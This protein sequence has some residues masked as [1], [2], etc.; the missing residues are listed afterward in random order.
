[1]LIKSLNQLPS[2]HQTNQSHVTWRTAAG[3]ILIISGGKLNQFNPA[4][5]NKGLENIKSQ[6]MT[7]IIHN[8][9]LVHFL[10]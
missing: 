3:K 6:K 10:I 7:Q 1:M 2:N 8:W 5:V 4:G 9:T